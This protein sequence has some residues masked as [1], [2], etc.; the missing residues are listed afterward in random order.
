MILPDVAESDDTLKIT[1]IIMGFYFILPLF[2]E[3]KRN[4]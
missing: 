2:P 3:V 1:V 4:Y